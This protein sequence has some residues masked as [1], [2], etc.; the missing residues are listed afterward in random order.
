MSTS[1]AKRQAVKRLASSA[2]AADDGEQ[3]QQDEQYNNQQHSR[4]F[5]KIRLNPIKSS[6]FSGI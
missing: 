6:Q 4:Y 2:L 5:R 1:P 3:L